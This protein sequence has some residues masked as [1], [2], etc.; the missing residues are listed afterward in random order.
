MSS[1]LGLMSP[2]GWLWTKMTAAADSTPAELHCR[3]DLRCLGG[4]D[5]LDPAEL[6]D[7]R[8]GNAREAAEPFQELAPKVNGR[9]AALARPEDDTK[10]LGVGQSV[11]SLLQEP[12]PR[13]LIFRPVLE[14][15]SFFVGQSMVRHGIQARAS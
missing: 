14:V 1:W 6:M 2:L 3:L 7:P 8:A 15:F 12:L 13:P 4:T 9:A 11:R 10:E 5:P